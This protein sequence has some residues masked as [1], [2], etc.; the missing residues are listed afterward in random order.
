MFT[1][2]DKIFVGLVGDDDKIALDGKRSHF[3]GLDTR[4]DQTAGILRC[5]V[6]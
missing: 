3:F 6:V 4:K 5:V 2:I 1:I